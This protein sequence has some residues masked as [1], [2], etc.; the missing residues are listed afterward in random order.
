MIAVQVANDAVKI[1]KTGLGSIEMGKTCLKT[2]LSLKT[3]N[4]GIRFDFIVNQR[5]DHPIQL[6]RNRGP[7]DFGEAGRNRG[8][9]RN[10]GLSSTRTGEHKI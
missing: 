1:H 10:Q 8:T 5:L 7:G 2:K 6:D 4:I 3:R 9:V